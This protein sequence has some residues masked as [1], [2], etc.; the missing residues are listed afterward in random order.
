[1]DVFRQNK[2]KV[3]YLYYNSYKD[4]TDWSTVNSNSE[5]KSLFDR[6]DQ[7]R[8]FEISSTEEAKKEIEETE[9][10]L[11]ELRSNTLQQLLEDRQF[12]QEM[13]ENVKCNKLLLFLL[14]KGYI[15][16]NYA[17]LFN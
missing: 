5:L 8:K 15:N 9:K 13:P 14:R 11:Q 2:M 4:C 1:M 12:E 6:Y 17:D 16:E 10:K 3:S 7:Y